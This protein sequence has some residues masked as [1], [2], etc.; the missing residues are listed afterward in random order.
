MYIIFYQNA[1]I[2][3]IAKEIF[4][5]FF[6]ILSLK[7]QSVFILNSTSHFRLIRS[8]KMQYVFTFNSTSHLDIKPHFQCSVAMCGK[9]PPCWTAQLKFVCRYNF[10]QSKTEH[11][12]TP[13][14]EQYVK[15]SVYSNG[16]TLIYMNGS[17]LLIDFPK[18]C[19]KRPNLSHRCFKSSLLSLSSGSSCLPL[20]AVNRSL[21]LPTP[22]P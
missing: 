12:H 2:S 4:Y 15:H 11:C 6:F 13:F 7:M 16:L 19:E 20:T 14:L 8:L 1:V 5:S 18:E 21:V 9:W 17:L 10:F 3:K 22:I